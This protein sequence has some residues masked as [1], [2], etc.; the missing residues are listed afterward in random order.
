MT[1]RAIRARPGHTRHVAA[2]SAWWFEMGKTVKSRPVRAA[3]S[4]LA[5]GHAYVACHVSDTHFEPSFF[6]QYDL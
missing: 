6:R 1:R 3:M 4:A 2:S 5:E